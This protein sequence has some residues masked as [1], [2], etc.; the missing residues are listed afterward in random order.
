[1]ESAPNQ[2]P[3]T[4]ASTSGMEPTVRVTRDRV[5]KPPASSSGTSKIDA[6]ERI[7]NA[8]TH[9]IQENHRLKPLGRRLGVRDAGAKFNTASIRQ[10]LEAVRP[11]AA[12]SS[13]AA[14]WCCFG[15]PL[16]LVGA[17]SG[18]SGE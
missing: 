2:E 18:A 11:S 9:C 12:A 8:A 1:M 4:S 13:S 17:S 7:V 3:I 14:A 6:R 10:I 16:A 5:A 15:T